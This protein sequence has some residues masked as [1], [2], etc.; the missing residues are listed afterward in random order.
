MSRPLTVKELGKILFE[1]FDRDKWGGIDPWHFKNPPKSD[2]D[3]GG[4]GTGLYEVLER[5]ADRINKRLRL[6]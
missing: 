1:E 6:K 2:D 3:L 5:V 4:E